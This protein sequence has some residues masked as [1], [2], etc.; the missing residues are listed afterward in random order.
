MLLFVSSLHSF[1]RP[2]PQSYSLGHRVM[3][4]FDILLLNFRIVCISSVFT[5]TFPLFATLLLPDTSIRD[6]Y[7]MNLGK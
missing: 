4:V 5:Y 3:F 1:S 7:L 6:R 2:P